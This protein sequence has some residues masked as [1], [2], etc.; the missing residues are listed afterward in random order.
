[1]RKFQITCQTGAFALGTLL[2][3]FAFAPAGCNS[4]QSAR[5]GGAPSVVQTA[6]AELKSQ[7]KPQLDASSS[8]AAGAVQDK[9]VATAERGHVVAGPANLRDFNP[10][11]TAVAP[12]VSSEE[13]DLR[14]IFEDLGPD[15]TLWYQHVQTLANPF[16]EGRWPTSRGC[17]LAA[18]YIEFYFKQY[19][20]EP[21]FPGEIAQLGGEHTRAFTSFRQPFDFASPSPNVKVLQAGNSINGEPLIDG[22]DFTVLGVS[23]DG[24]ITAPVTFVGYGI[25][26]GQDDYT[27]FDEQVDLTGRIAMVLRYEPLNDEGKSQWSTARFSRFAGVALK[28]KALTDRGAAGIILVNPPGAVDGKTG[29][30]S[31]RDSSRF[32][33]RLKIPAFQVTPE[34]ADRIIR[35]GDGQKRDLLTLR[36]LADKGEIKTLNLDE[37]VLVSLNSALHVDDRMNT[38]NVAAVLR[39]KGNLADQWVVIGAHYDH[40]GFGYTGAR[41]QNVGKLHPG[42]DDNASGTAAVLIAAK[43][44]SQNYADSSDGANLRSVMFVAFS[45]EEAGLFG[46]KKFVDDNPIDPKSINLMINMDMIGRLRSNNLLVQGTGTAEGLA[47]L[48]KPHFEKSGLTISLTLGGGGPSDHATFYRAGIPVLFLFT[49]EH[50]EYHQ[51]TDR[52]YTVNPA[53]AMKVIELLEDITMEAASRPERLKYVQTSAGGGGR[54]TGAR[55]RLGIQPDYQAELETGVKVEAVSEGTS[56]AVAGIQAGDILLTWNG[57]AL[58]GGQK[59]FEFLSKAEPGEKVTIV[60]LRGEREM[61]VEVTLKPRETNE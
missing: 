28:M 47:T 10:K 26:H 60:L 51:P 39:G 52:A 56:A 57:E 59:L 13:V 36:Q 53:G 50:P 23:G 48:C 29:L 40:V 35:Q 4:E 43:R 22:S 54:N 44:L 3:V 30:E 24:N 61:T 37:S 31:L 16:F 45:A 11:N 38:Q 5:A 27:S 34:V 6:N 25:E 1:M 12:S 33:P 32:G 21:A 2:A 14:K 42:A 58:A 46:S 8:V 15:A 49:G 17:E 55:V 19:G 20:L 18:E 41:P 7:A 9:G